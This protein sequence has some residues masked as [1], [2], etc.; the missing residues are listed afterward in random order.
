MASGKSSWS[1]WACWSRGAG[2]IAAHSARPVLDGEGGGVVGDR[3]AQNGDITGGRRGGLEGIGGVGQD[4]VHIFGDEAVH[5]GAAVGVLAAGVL[6]LEGDR[7]AQRL[8]DRVLEALGGGVQRV[9]GHLLADADHIGLFT[10]GAVAAGLI[11]R[12]AGAARQRRRHG[13]RGEQRGQLDRMFH[14][15]FILSSWGGSLPLRCFNA[16]W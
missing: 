14:V 16:F 15:H 9:V 5:D 4:Q 12:A 7:V 2:D 10:A 6:L 1:I 8:G 3:S 13:G 11:G